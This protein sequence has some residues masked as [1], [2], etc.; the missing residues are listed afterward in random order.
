MSCLFTWCLKD[1]TDPN[2]NKTSKILKEPI[3]NSSVVLIVDD[4][5]ESVLENLLE[6]GLNTVVENTTG[7]DISG[8]VDTFVKKYVE[9]AVEKVLNPEIELGI[10]T[11][12]QATESIIIP[13]VIDKTSKEQPHVLERN[14]SKIIKK[15]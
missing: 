1:S 9:P 13:V 10:N 11:I 5:E 2:M 6:P 3:T 12:K 14:K 7:Q 15:G 4:L 8:V